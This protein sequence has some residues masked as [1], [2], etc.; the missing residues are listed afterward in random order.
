MT[1]KQIEFNELAREHMLA[2]VAKLADAVKVTLGPRGRNVVLERTFGAPIITNDGGLRG[3]RD[4]TRGRVREY[5]RADSEEHRGRDGGCHRGR[6]DDRY[7]AGSCD[8]ARGQ[9]NGGRGA[10]RSGKSAGIG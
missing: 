3:Q 5:G 2:G 7:R 6:H 8:C 4:R 10:E 1:A 9:E